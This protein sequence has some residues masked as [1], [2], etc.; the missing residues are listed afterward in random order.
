LIEKFDL[1]FNYLLCRRS[2]FI[3]IPG[4]LVLLLTIFFFPVI[5][6]L[7][8]NLFYMNAARNLF[9][10][11]IYLS[12]LKEYQIS[13]PIFYSFILSFFSWTGTYLSQVA[14]V[15]NLILIVLSYLFI[16]KN[17]FFQDSTFLLPLV[18]VNFFFFEAVMLEMTDILFL[19]QVFFFLYLVSLKTS[20]LRFFL[21]FLISLISSMTKFSAILFPISFVLSTVCNKL[22]FKENF[23]KQKL[24]SLCLV[25][26]GFVIGV[27]INSMIN[28][29]H[30]DVLSIPKNM[31]WVND[32]SNI[33]VM[34]KN[35]FFE[36]LIKISSYPG[37]FNLLASF[38]LPLRLLGNMVISIFLSLPILFLVFRG[39]YI[40]A[41]SLKKIPFEISFLFIYVCLFI[42]TKAMA[43]RHLIII[44]PILWFLFLKGVQGF[45]FKNILL[46]LSI[47][48]NL[49][50][51]FWFISFGN[52]GDH[53]GLVN[54]LRN[55]PFYKNEYGD[56]YKIINKNRDLLRDKKIITR[57]NK[58]RFIS[59]WLQQNI[60]FAYD[61]IEN[62]DTNSDAYFF[63]SKKRV[64]PSENEIIH[65]TLESEKYISLYKLK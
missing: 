18:F 50:L 6:Q 39:A 59:F 1:F 28:Y 30:T 57:S 31:I 4:A 44:Y 56:I 64:R 24:I 13:W 8:D 47:G 21:I 11:N 27:K 33:L 61:P 40:Y 45:K 19:F 20:G 55:K 43:T 52:R 62:L 14:R 65:E 37:K 38:F 23:N 26:I 35:I 42:C 7:T 22:F 63:T 48:A 16:K 41:K 29:Y 9:E 32:F 15:L 10:S 58:G 51:I 12:G 34:I 5:P 54:I 46:F 36:N 60:V 17:R 25:V 3:L 49:G 2:K 53:A